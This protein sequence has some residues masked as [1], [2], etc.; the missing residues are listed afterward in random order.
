MKMLGGLRQEIVFARRQREIGQEPGWI[1]VPLIVTSH[2]GENSKTT[3]SHQ[4]P[5]IGEALR[6]EMRDTAR[7]LFQVAAHSAVAP[8]NSVSPRRGQVASLIVSHLPTPHQP[9]GEPA[10]HSG[11]TG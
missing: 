10:L 3:Q 4:A 9:H 8:L 11:E 6:G 7:V 2:T 5:P 1:S